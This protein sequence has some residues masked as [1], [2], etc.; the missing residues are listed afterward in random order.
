MV[1]HVWMC[2]KNIKHLTTNVRAQMVDLGNFVKLKPMNAAVI[3]VRMV[4][5]VWI[6]TMDT[7]AIVYQVSS[8]LNYLYNTIKSW[9]VSLKG[10]SGALC[11]IDTNECHQSYPCKNGGVCVDMNNEYNAI[12]YQVGG[13]LNYLYQYDTLKCWWCECPSRVNLGSYLK[14]TT[15]NATVFHVEYVWMW[16]MDTSLIVYQVFGGLNWSS[17]TLK[18]WQVYPKDHYLRSYEKLLSFV[19][20]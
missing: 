8:G 13:G 12:V 14:L 16:T 11:E 17:C 7:N 6:W 18:S 19:F 1:L 3:H 5:Y 15:M 20:K 2:K 4:E 10:Q 9:W